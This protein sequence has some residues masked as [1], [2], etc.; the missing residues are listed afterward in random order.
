MGKFIV[1]TRTNGEFMFDLYADNH[2]VILTSQGY[3]TKANCMNGIESVRNNAQEDSRFKH[4]VAKDGRFYFNL[5]SGN[6][7]VVGTSQMYTTQDACMKG[8][9]SVMNN[10]PSASVEEKL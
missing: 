1:S 10:A 8:T 9:Q 4:E 2:Q 7:Q 6:G 3:T 5:T